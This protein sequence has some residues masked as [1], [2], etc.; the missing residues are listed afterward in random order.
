[1]E[2][3]LND[4]DWIKYE[5][6]IIAEDYKKY[7]YAETNL[8]KHKSI[9]KECFREQDLLHFYA[10]S[11]SISKIINFVFFH[12]D[13][14]DKLIDL[15]M[16]NKKRLTDKPIGDISWFVLNFDNLV[17]DYEFLI[18]TIKNYNND[19]NLNG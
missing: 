4:Y 11:T 9:I 18:T 13:K 5:G 8:E 19:I 17:E 12:P 6:K 3:L 1:M 2:S 14:I 7:V 10:L 15:Y 16:K